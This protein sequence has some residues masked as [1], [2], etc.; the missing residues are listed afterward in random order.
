MEAALT[1]YTAGYGNLQP[2]G[3]ALTSAYCKNDRKLTA[4]KKKAE[5]E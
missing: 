1:E 4:Q 3:Q 5:E 2:E